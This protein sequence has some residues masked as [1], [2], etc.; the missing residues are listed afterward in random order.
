MPIQ[1]LSPVIAQTPRTSQHFFGFYDISPW[2]PDGRSL[3]TL[4]LAAM[5]DRDPTAEDGCEVCIWTLQTGEI[6]P[7]ATTSAW[8]Y[9]QGARARWLSD[10]SI[11]FNDRDEQGPVARVVSADG[12]LIRTIPR[13]VYAL[14]RD[15]TF[16]VSPSFG[17]LGRYYPPYGYAGA[18]APSIEHASPEDDGVWLTDFSTGESRLLVSLAALA[19]Q[20][21]FPPGCKQ[22]VSHFEFSPDD[23]RFYFYHAYITDDE[24]IF[25]RLM[26]VDRDGS[27]L[28]CIADEKLGHILWYDDATLLLWARFSPG[29]KALRRGNS[30]RHPWLKGLVRSAWRWQ[31]RLRNALLNEGVFLVPVDRPADRKRIAVGEIP[32]DGHFLMHPELNCMVGDT[33][34]DRTNQLHLYIYDFD[35]DRCCN[36]ASFGHGVGAVSDAYRCDLHPR[37]SPDGRK[38]AVDVCEEGVRRLTVVDVDRALTKLEL[39][40]KSQS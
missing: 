13:G 10:G 11:L 26:V 30:L 40:T 4:R 14:S 12:R 1:I 35:S 3:L 21:D 31:G 7:V 16:A 19:R 2:S 6:R 27:D 25:R 20:A 18:D 37:W 33:Y 28:R 38:I 15:E 36:V 24:A 17:R 23:S 22:M 32:A 5:P 34:P 39:A 9:Q 8:N 29:M